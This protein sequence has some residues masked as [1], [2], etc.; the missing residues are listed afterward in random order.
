MPERPHVPTPFRDQTVLLW[1]TSQRA[2]WRDKRLEGVTKEI[3]DAGRYT[4]AE[5]LSFQL[6]HDV[7]QV[8]NEE[9]ALQIWNSAIRAKRRRTPR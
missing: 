5:L 9:A 2:F 8:L 3:A 4:R 6:D 7:V 1:D